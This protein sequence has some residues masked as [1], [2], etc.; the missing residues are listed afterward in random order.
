V[1]NTKNRSIRL[2]LNL[3]I[4]V[5]GLLLVVQMSGT[6]IDAVGRYAD[7]RRVASLASTSRSLFKT[8]MA[9]RLERG[10]QNASLV[11]DRPIDSAAE[12]DL[13]GYRRTAEEGYAES[14]AALPSIDLPGL[15]PVA[16]ALRVAHDKVAGL[17]SRADAAVHQG[18]DERDVGLVQDYPKI[19]QDLLDAVISTND[20]LDA[21]LKL[22]DPTV[23][24][25]LS[26]KRAAW[27]TR[28]NL[29][30]SGVRMQ[31]A[32]AGGK[33][34]QTA[35]LIAWHQDRARAQAAW[36]VV[37][38]AAKRPDAPRALVDTAAKAGMNFAGPYF[39]TLKSLG[40]KLV[41]GQPLG[42]DL[43]ELRRNDTAAAG[44]VVDVVNIA[45]NEMV[46]R[47]EQQSSRAVR[48]LVLD[49]LLLLVAV[50]VSVFGF[51]FVIRR[52]SHPIKA[53]TD[54]ISRL[55]EQDYAVVIPSTGNDDEIGQMTEALARL[56]DNAKR[57]QEEERARL[58]D[59]EERIAKATA[60]DESCRRFDV[61]VGGNIGAVE[62]AVAQ[63]VLSA[64]NMTEIAQHSSR[65]STSVG[66][67]ANEA[68]ANV[69]TVAAA[70][71]ELSS[72]V[73][74]IN[75]QMAQST[76]ISSEAMTKAEETGR[77]IAGLSAAN[78]KIDEIVV[79][80]NGIAS[81]TNLLALNATIE[82]ARAGEAGKGF[83]VVANEVKSLANQTAKATEEI[84]QQIAQI[85]TMTEDAV[86]GVR[87]MSEVIHNMD[88]VTTGIAAA[89]EEQGAATSEIAR[90]VHEAASA[91]NRITAQMGDVKLTVDRSKS[92]AD[93]VRTAA[94]SM[95]EQ[96][97]ALKT[98]VAEF[99][100]SVR[101]A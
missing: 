66:E 63:L 46:S 56:R 75:R 27:A 25:F 8:L 82:A 51:F 99:L 73:A 44:S 17:R 47:A 43:N 62:K 64:K 26:V 85:Q 16:S 93:E 72:S 100:G 21:S 67:A 35:D 57:G 58:R 37:E 30:L 53:L 90:N 19:T 59:Q 78:Q 55:A 6:V 65:T 69:S 34:W 28:L 94:E 41:S 89:L 74:E 13:A 101:T 9:T 61:Q 70:T 39:E 97:M 2:I 45:L 54:L 14:M 86:N 49:S 5:M 80:I 60:V 18:K 81:Q 20:L 32:I 33:V 83:A 88:R 50:G 4:G 96:S 71:E 24:H 3:V 48:A 1:R 84:A 29:G 31:P 98:E 76:Q 22:T 10:L 52:V 79:M 87:S 38:E 12:A 42:V 15:A 95:R 91:T 40:D 36:Q 92:M 77:S 7:A 68:S 11:G 23:D